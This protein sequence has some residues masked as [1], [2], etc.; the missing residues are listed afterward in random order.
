MGSVIDVMVV[1]DMLVA[2]TVDMLVDVLVDVNVVL[3]PDS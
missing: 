1:V 2:T 3:M